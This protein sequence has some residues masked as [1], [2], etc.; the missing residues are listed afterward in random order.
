VKLVI[1]RRL[2]ITLSSLIV[3]AVAIGILSSLGMWQLQRAD[4]KASRLESLRS[5]QAKGLMPLDEVSRLSD[6]RDIPVRVSGEL[7][8]ENVFLWDNRIVSGKVGYEAIVPL[9]TANGIVLVN[10]GWLQGTG[11]RDQ[12]P[13]VMVPEFS[14]FEGVVWLP[15]D[16]KFIGSETLSG[17]KWPVLIQ[18]VDINQIGGVL[19]KTLMPFVVALELPESAGFV[20]NHKPVV[21]PPDKHIAYAVQWFGLAIACFVI[22]IVASFKKG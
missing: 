8:S 17:N 3:T 20:N 15:Q 18:E 9:K 11:Y 22:F 21:M 6:P 14:Q 7:Q 2:N 10:L 5:K 19:G 4:Q 13:R 12:L 1:F 16:N